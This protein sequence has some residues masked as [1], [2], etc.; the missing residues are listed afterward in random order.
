MRYTTLPSGSSYWTFTLVH[1]I[2]GDAPQYY[3]HAGTPR[4]IPPRGIFL[5]V[6][7]HLLLLSGSSGFAVF[8]HTRFSII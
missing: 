7:P 8:K 2:R 1:Y 4:L 5:C 3:Y 6:G